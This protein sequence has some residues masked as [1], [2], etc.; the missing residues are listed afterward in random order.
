MVGKT[1]AQHKEGNSAFI[2]L[3]N[4]QSDLRSKLLLTINSNYKRIIY[5]IGNYKGNFVLFL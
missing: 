5:Q 1:V 3:C 4:A 2:L